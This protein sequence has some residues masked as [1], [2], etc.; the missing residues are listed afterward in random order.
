[1]E[2]R[3]VNNEKT[4]L[5]SVKHNHVVK[6]VDTFV[7]NKDIFIVMEYCDGGTLYDYIRKLKCQMT[8]DLFVCFLKQIAEGLK[9]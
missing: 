6:F 2:E 3:L 8:E 4:I 9:V 7:L 5:Q 1:M